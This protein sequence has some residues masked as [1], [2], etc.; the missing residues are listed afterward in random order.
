MK[1][2]CYCDSPIGKMLLVGGNG[3]MEELHFPKGLETLQIP[4]TWQKNEACFAEA[5]RQLKEYFAGS[6]REFQL[7][8]APHGTPFQKRVWQELCKIPYGETASYGAIAKKI[9]NPKA[10]RAVGMANNKNPIPIIIPC[11]RIIGKDGSLTGFG[12]GLTVKKQLLDLERQ[13]LNG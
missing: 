8:I 4:T 1:R 9:G 3:I 12:G 10:C 13:S 11:H 6:R 5:L 2:Y 7:P